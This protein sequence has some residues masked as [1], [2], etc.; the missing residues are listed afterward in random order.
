MPK[1]D[2]LCRAYVTARNN[3][4]SQ[5]DAFA[6]VA[7]KVNESMHAVLGAPPFTVY[8]V[9]NSRES[10]SVKQRTAATSVWFGQDGLWHFALALSLIGKIPGA[11]HDTSPQVVQFEAIGTPT[12]NGFALTMRGTEEK[13][14]LPA[15]CSAA[16]CTAFCEFVYNRVLDSYNQPG[17]VFLEN[18]TESKRT[19]GY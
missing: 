5:R 13:F 11:R 14:E 9:P 18:V 17:Q 12:T 4:L 2:D 16:D 10:G 6:L 7:T 19:I 15:N 1:Y 8:Y 3:Y